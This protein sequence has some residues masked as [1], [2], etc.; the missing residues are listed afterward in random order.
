LA[1]LEDVVR[2]DA[3]GTLELTDEDRAQFPAGTVDLT[4]DDDEYWAQFSGG[5]LQPMNFAPVGYR[6]GT[7]EYVPGFRAYNPDGSQKQ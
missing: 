7:D 2:R 3:E 5:N 1:D 6:A 4:D